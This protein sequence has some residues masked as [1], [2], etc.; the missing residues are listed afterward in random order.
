MSHLK[1]IFSNKQQVP[2]RVK[3]VHILTRT[4]ET[5]LYG[6]KRSPDNGAEINRY[7][8]Q[9]AYAHPENWL[10]NETKDVNLTSGTGPR[11]NYMYIFVGLKP[12]STYYFRVR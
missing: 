12:G 4:N 7:E 11:N 8:V 10:R 2:S 5:L 1:N 9:L 3:N 6:W